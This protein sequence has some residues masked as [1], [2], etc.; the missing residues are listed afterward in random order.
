MAVRRMPHRALLLL[1]PLTT[2][3][4]GPGAARTGP[5]TADRASDQR[6]FEQRE[7]EILREL[8]ALDRRIA[9]R[10]RVT[11]T[12][13][14]LRR[15]TMAA[16]LRE[17]PTVAVIDGAIDPFS[18]E[19][20][21]RGLEA[22]K[23]KIAALPKSAVSE[24]RT[25]ERDLFLRLVEG[26]LMRVEEERA[27]PRS[28]SALVRALVDG[29][30]AP[31][32]AEEAA[33]IDRWITRRLDELGAA[34]M[35][36]ADPKA[37]LDVVRARELDDSL[38]ALERI[39]SLPG[40]TRA[41][42]A[43][44]RVREALETTSSKPAAK[45]QS[46]WALVARR[47]QAHLGTTDSPETLADNLARAAV[48]L[49]ARAESSMTRAGLSSEQLASLL[50]KQ[51]FVS[52]PCMDAV[53][54]SRVRSMAAPA[55]REPSCHLRHLVSN[56]EDETSRALAFAVMHDHV[57]VAQ[58]ALD[59]ARGSATIAETQARHRLL[60]PMMPNTSAR[61]E[62]FAL[63]R[64]V[65]AIGAGETARL[66]LLGDPQTRARAWATLGDV[67]PNVASRE[68]SE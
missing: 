3:A 52:V 19:A 61:Y 53:P 22:A 40:F 59:V 18:F 46:D 29:W 11:P 20:R 16:M 57:V 17:D 41:M 64:P 50:E 26:E 4:C 28:A 44:V 35:A 60:V 23:Q 49:R 7:D 31:S 34:M 30:H 66:L 62:R 54:G 10:A 58:W 38:D 6:A 25:S 42:Q 9:R 21:K 2:I 32:S 8:A 65:A 13:D 37:T 68:L 63:A 1:I 14:G 39:V 51:V 45:A 56:I 24:K 43:L 12:E 67:P 15:I 47:A 5:E 33:D 55:E 27:L 48:D 36:S